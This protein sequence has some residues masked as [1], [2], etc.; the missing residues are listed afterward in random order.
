MVITVLFVDDNHLN[1]TDLVT[2]VTL[3]LSYFVSSLGMA[4]GRVQNTKKKYEFF[5][6]SP[7]GGWVTG[8]FSYFSTAFL[9]NAQNFP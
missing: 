9:K 1:M 6:T 4:K 5:H 2:G 3:T 7:G 8:H